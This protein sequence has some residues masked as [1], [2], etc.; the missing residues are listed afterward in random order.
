MAADVFTASGQTRVFTGLIS[1]TNKPFR[2]TV[3]WTDAPGSTT[4]NAY[5]NN[6]DLTVTVSGQTY[7]GNV[8]SGAYSV[9]GGSAGLKNNVG[10]GFL[11]AGGS[12]S[13]GGSGTGRGESRQ[14][15]RTG[16]CGG[17]LQRN[18]RGIAGH[19]HAGIGPGGRKHHAD[20]RRR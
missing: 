14:C 12:G 11:P 15:Q 8:F 4:G 16:F 18:E 2:V 13:F 9:T 7:K 3:A 20:Q 19:V 17:G 5:K 10:S 1:D 6:L